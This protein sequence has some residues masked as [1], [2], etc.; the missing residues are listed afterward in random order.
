MKNVVKTLLISV[1]VV[2]LIGTFLTG[3]G[4]SEQ[5]GDTDVKPSSDQTEKADETKEAKNV[6]LTFWGYPFGALEGQKPG[7]FFTTLA[8]EFSKKNPNVKINTEIIPYEGG[9]QKVNV[10]LASKS[11]PDVLA[12]YPGRTVAY[13]KRG[14]AV[15]LNDI[16]TDEQKEK[17]P[18]Y[19]LDMCSLPD[20]TIYTYPNFL[21]ATGLI[22]NKTLVEKAGALDF[23]PKGE[24]RA[25]T[26]EEFEK[27]LQT[28]K[29]KAGDDVYPLMLYALNEQGDVIYFNFME[30]FGGKKFSEDRKNCVMNSKESVQ[31]LEYVKS[32]LDKGLIA[33]NPETRSAGNSI[34]Y[35]V[36][37]KLVAS[38]GNSATL[39]AI[40]K[41]VEEGALKEKFE[42]ML[43]P[44]PCVEDGKGVLAAS[45]GYLVAFKSGD[46][47]RESYA[48]QYISYIGSENPDASKAF[49]NVD[50]FGRNEYLDNA[51]P[52]AQWIAKAMADKNMYSSDPSFDIDGYSE[53]RAV[54]FPEI[55][56]MF[57]G[58]KTP[59]QAMDDFV[60][61]ADD[62][63]K[64]NTK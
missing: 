47:D 11:A 39:K 41:A 56:A 54:F 53:I 35:F 25:W 1:L 17:I 63:I 5:K 31:A 7:D 29:G 59:Q 46:A 26:P 45:G 32:L 19:L 50:V 18:E 27:F 40:D 13:A 4:K 2:T 20:G 34:D 38:L 10:A 6:E 61:K 58:S 49:G 30:G 43:V 14:Y 23:L 36:Q 33:P 42:A 57:I 3:C 60:K 52:E 64:R 62:I 9:D 15:P 28:V 24:N 37:G 12:D 44:Y 48:K 21:N 22:I 16:I 55:Q 8:E 51:H